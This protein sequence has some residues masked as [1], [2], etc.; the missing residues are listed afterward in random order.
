MR[1]FS[2]FFRLFSFW[3]RRWIVPPYGTQLVEGELPELLR[4]KTIYIV[5]EDGYLWHASMLCPC[6]CHAV[7]HM[8]LVPDERPFW[9]LTK[10]SDGTVSLFPSVWR[11]KDCR[12]HF[13]FCRGRVIWCDDTHS[14]ARTELG[15]HQQAGGLN[16]TTSR[17]TRHS[18][19]CEPTSRVAP[20]R[21]YL[22]HPG[23]GPGRSI[24]GG[25]VT[26]ELCSRRCPSVP[27]SFGSSLPI[28]Q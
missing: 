2:Q 4:P 25:S 5:Q 19:V 6:G 27:G 10:H 17:G 28:R 16:K 1:W 24:A 7:L 14:G 20:D 21:G 13:W 3:I 9:R 26:G 23:V 11:K 22:A 15:K 12:C 18:V 8:N